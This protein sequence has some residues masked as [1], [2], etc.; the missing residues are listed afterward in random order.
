MSNSSRN[1]V[2]GLMIFFLVACAPSGVPVTADSPR[3]YPTHLVCYQQ[4]VAVVDAVTTDGVSLESVDVGE[5]IIR[6]WV[7]DDAYGH[8]FI[9]RSD[10]LACSETPAR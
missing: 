8:H 5:W 9:E 3:T 10:S 4:G 1:I 7:W 6:A 2:I